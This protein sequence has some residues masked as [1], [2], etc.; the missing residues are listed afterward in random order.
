M[1]TRRA[2]DDTGWGMLK[3]TVYASD[4]FVDS[5]S[6]ALRLRHFA[7]VSAHEMVRRWNSSPTWWRDFEH[8]RGVDEFVIEDD[9]S[10]GCRLLAH[11]SDT[12]L[13]LLEMGGKDI[14][15]RYSSTK[16][17]RDLRERS[18][19]SPQFLPGYRS[20]VF[21]DTEGHVAPHF[22]QENAADWV[23]FL[24]D[25][26]AQVVS[27]LEDAALEAITSSHSSI[28]LV[29]GGPGTGKTVVLANL[30]LRLAELPEFQVGLCAADRLVDYLEGATGADLQ[31]FR[32]TI[33]DLQERNVLLVDDP[34]TYED[35]KWSV[36]TAPKGW[37]KVV[38]VAFDPLQLAEALPDAEYSRLKRSNKIPEFQLATCYRQKANVG[39]A[40]KR[41]IDTV[42]ESSPYLREDKQQKHRREHRKL[43]HLSNDLEFVNP[44]GRERVYED[45]SFDDLVAEV[46][47]LE[48]TGQLWRHWPPLLIVVDDTLTLTADAK[49]LLAGISHDVVALRRAQAVKGLEYQYVFLFL[50]RS[51][52]DELQHG[53]NGTGRSEYAGR[54]LLRI[55][56]SRAK[57]GIVTFVSPK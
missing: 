12:E 51:T 22:P 17:R 20:V 24:D 8:V 42:A 5:Y 39:L 38:V 26:Q 6:R 16:L 47:R 31:R 30:L 41:V 35:I 50:A 25:H 19:A 1:D 11:P 29:L 52:Y 18:T 57:D 14:V 32:V 9:L 37:C 36:L 28:G 55:P 43:T 3:R 54:R 34:A 48:Q 53:F 21:H 49:E 7:E 44:G 40:T 13:T 23:M 45:T 15:E 46:E 27:E 2:R 4:R 33:G 56:F 10:G